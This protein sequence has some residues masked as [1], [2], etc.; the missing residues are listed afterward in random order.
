MVAKYVKIW[1]NKGVDTLKKSFAVILCILLIFLV[2]IGINI[3]ELEKERK[4]VQ[5][6]NSYYEQYNKQELNGLDITTVINKAINNNEKFN[7]Q[8]NEEG[9][10]INDGQNS[11]QIYITMII[12][13]KTYPM[14][15]INALGMESFIEYFGVVNFKCSK[16]E[17]H[18]QTGK[19]SSMTFE[20]TEY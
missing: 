8:K 4:E 11:V 5:K 14:E 6:F 16:V 3:K 7:I 1:Y 12:N 2:I 19:I 9:L 10:Y 17:Y 18:E 13:N 15:K 20:A